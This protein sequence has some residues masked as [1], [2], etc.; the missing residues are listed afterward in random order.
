LKNSRVVVT[1]GNSP[2]L[3]ALHLAPQSETAL[4]KSWSCLA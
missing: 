1:A 2:N 3:A 4:L